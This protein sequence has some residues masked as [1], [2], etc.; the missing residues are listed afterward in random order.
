MAASPG[1]AVIF[2]EG[3]DSSFDLISPGP[4]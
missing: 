4:L 3:G 2:R 1:L